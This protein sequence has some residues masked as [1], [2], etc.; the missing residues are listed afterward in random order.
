M[1]SKRGTELSEIP[2][3]ASCVCP[4]NTIFTL[5]TAALV[6]YLLVTYANPSNHFRR[7]LVCTRASVDAENK[8]MYIT[9]NAPTT[10]IALLKYPLIAACIRIMIHVTNIIISLNDASQL[11][12]RASGKSMYYI[13][14]NQVLLFTADG[15]LVIPIMYNAGVTC[16]P[17]I[18]T[19]VIA[20][21]MAPSILMSDR[22]VF[23]IFV[24]TVGRVIIVIWLFCTVSD[25]ISGLSLAFIIIDIVTGPV[26]TVIANL[27]ECAMTLERSTTSVIYMAIMFGRFVVLAVLSCIAATRSID[28]VEFR[29]GDNIHENVWTFNTLA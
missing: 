13:I 1:S 10:Y 12:E 29:T 20:Y 27:I 14:F 17:Y 2:T 9:T 28:S 19:A 26:T 16:A 8:K 6:I 22:N 25:Q 11:Y 4:I 15:L 24:F 7:P 3:A 21:I 23:T 18:V 5:V